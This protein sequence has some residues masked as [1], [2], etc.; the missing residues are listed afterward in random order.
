MS[1]IY[2]ITHRENKQDFENIHE[3]ND[4]TSTHVHIKGMRLQR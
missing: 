4:S 2:L 1:S 3:T